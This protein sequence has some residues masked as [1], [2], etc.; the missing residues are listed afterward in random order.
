MKRA[1]SCLTGPVG[2][3]VVFAAQIGLLT[4]IAG[5]L[6]GPALVLA[7]CAGVL[8]TALAA[9]WRDIRGLRALDARDL[10]APALA[11]VLM[12][13]LAPYLV[14]TNRYS[15]APPGTELIFFAAVGWGAIAVGV[16]A[17]GL[18]RRGGRRGALSA[19]AGALAAVT[20][21]AGILGS[22]ERP[23]SFSP[24]IRYATEEMWMLVAGAAFIGGGVLLA[25]ASVGKVGRERSLLVAAGAALACAVLPTVVAPG[26]LAA[27]GGLAEYG[28]TVVL[29]SAAWSLT[30]LLTTS[31]LA[32]ARPIAVGGAFMIA[33][34]LLPLLS[35]V[36]SVVGMAGPQP[37]VWG[38]VA[39]GSM[40]LFAGLARLARANSA[41]PAHSTPA[42]LRWP[43]LAF[44]VSALV[45]FAMPA[46][47]AHISAN[48]SGAAT[49]MTWTLP[50]W[51]T[52]GGWAALA[53]ALLLVAA[54][55]DDA[56]WVALAA[57]AAPAGYWLLGSTPYHVLTPLLSY[58]IQADLGTEYAAI[59]FQALTVWPA[60]I[61]V[62]GASAGLV[63]VLSSRLLRRL[64]PPAAPEPTFIEEC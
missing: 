8:I 41:D 44:A 30:V 16:G 7:A 63:V 56:P 33:P 40:V 13:F 5:R 28:A 45:G 35:G 27:V 23:S 1:L 42:W 48:R 51:E 62:V 31:M 4:S 19:L 11:G 26:S 10:R 58:D 17:W 22:W 46:M 21:A 54:T 18:L 34:A 9:G 6:P 49:E 38:G 37:I 50:G 64:R 12:L 29:W 3:A 24:L 2:L 57:F 14:V 25:R 43:A 55:L 52:V 36:E 39:G 59:T 53:C 61:A 15:D 20:G 47:S 60:L 32:E